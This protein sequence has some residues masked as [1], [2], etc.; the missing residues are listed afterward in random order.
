[1]T[2]ARALKSVIRS[3]IAKTGER[4]T[5]ARRHVLAAR[6]ATR[7]GALPPA[8]ATPSPAPS[9]AATA[10]GTVSDAK[11]RERTGHGLDHWFEVLDRFGAVEQGHTRAARHLHQDHGVDGWYSQ[12]ITV[13]Y[14]RARGLRVLN[15]RVDGVFEVSASKVVSAR[16]ADVVAAVSR[17][18]RRAA[19]ASAADPDLV[20][21]LVAALKSSTGF[22]TRADGLARFRYRWGATVVQ[23]YVEPKPGD[24]STITVANARLADA[25]MIETRRAQ[26]RAALAAL[27]AWLGAQD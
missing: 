16:P 14:E 26:W 19:W 18:R 20:A 22:V 25:A 9:P 3:R 24:K 8:E 15:Q 21:A 5:T 13:S 11:V 7:R 27:A 4:Y 2:R 12:G 6:T 23:W 1:M 10:K 17:P